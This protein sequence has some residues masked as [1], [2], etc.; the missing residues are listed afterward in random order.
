MR[1][2]ISALSLSTW[3]EIESNTMFFMLVYLNN[4][5]RC[6]D[7]TYPVIWNDYRIC[8]IYTCSHLKKCHVE[9]TALP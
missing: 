9:H 6:N 5:S 2:W 7:F 8:L 3:K 4:C 1:V